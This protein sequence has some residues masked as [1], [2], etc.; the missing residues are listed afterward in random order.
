MIKSWHLGCFTSDEGAT[1]S[2][3][4]TCYSCDDLAKYSGFKFFCSNIIQEKKRA[5][6]CHCNI[7]QTMI[8]KISANGVMTVS[9]KKNFLLFFYTIH[10]KKQK[11]KLFFF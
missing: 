3:T 2:F 10:T 1:S 6:P 7:I 9:C 4:S 5:G 8:D 11:N